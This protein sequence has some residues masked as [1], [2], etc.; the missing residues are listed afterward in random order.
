MKYLLLLLLLTGCVNLPEMGEFDL[1]D[2]NLPEGFEISVYA[3]VPNARSMAMGEGVLFVGT[4][5]G[6][7]YAV[8]DEVIELASGLNMPNGVAFKDGSLFVAEVSRI[9]E[10]KNVLDNLDNATYEVVYSDFPSDTHH[11]WKYIAFGPDGLLY[12]PVGAPCNVCDEPDPYASLTRLNVSSG[13]REIIARGIRNTVGFDWVNGTLWFTDNGRDWLGDD[14]PPDELNKL[15]VGGHYGYPYCHGSIQDPEFGR[16]CDGF[17]SPEVELGPHVAA[18][19]MEYNDGSFSEYRGKIF[20]AEH[21]SWNREVPIGY[22]VTVVDPVAK[23]YDVFADG[24]LGDK[25][26][27][28]PVDILELDDSILVSDD[29]GGRIYRIRPDFH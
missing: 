3:E 15:V 25:V 18:L 1:S 9:I 20:I 6:E 28:R 4:R 29:F 10:F 19:G 16:E 5:E 27:G 14:S 13:E 23:T 21:G 24:W 11:G 7:V 22:R 12:V 17:I 8:K 26:S 2:I